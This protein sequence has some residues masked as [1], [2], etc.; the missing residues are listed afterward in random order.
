MR[1]SWCPWRRSCGVGA[2]VGVDVDVGIEEGKEEVSA[3]G[4]G[5]W[6]ETEDGGDGSPCLYS[7]EVVTEDRTTAGVAKEQATALDQDQERAGDCRRRHR[8][9]HGKAHPVKSMPSGRQSPLL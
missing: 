9:L 2:V 4:V 5:A 3:S 8:A 6:R 1:S 7:W